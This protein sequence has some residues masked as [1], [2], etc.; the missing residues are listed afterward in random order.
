M[1][2]QRLSAIRG[3]YTKLWKFQT[4][5]YRAQRLSAIRG[6]YLGI[7]VPVFILML[8]AQRLSAIRGLYLFAV[9]NQASGLK[10]AQRLS[11]IRGLYLVQYPRRNSPVN[12]LNAFR[13]SEV[14]T[15][16][17]VQKYQQFQVCST[18]FGN[19]RFVHK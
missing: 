16:V 5:L 6:L 11:A 8:R 14:C 12:V 1:R 4:K 17:A 3:L 7:S 19:Q 9:L 10:G 13:Q 18:P 2:A 15:L